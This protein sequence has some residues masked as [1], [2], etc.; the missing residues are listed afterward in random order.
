MPSRIE[1]EHGR[2]VSP[3]ES[4]MLARALQADL[5]P[6]VSL[7]AVA[8]EPAHVPCRMQLRGVSGDDY[9]PPRMLMRLM[10]PPSACIT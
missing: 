6:H 4:I 2:T 3:G 1:K 7:D 8:Q 9:L 5:T 10:S